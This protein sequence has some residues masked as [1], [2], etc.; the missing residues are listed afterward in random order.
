[1]QNKKTTD[2]KSY[3]QIVWEQF[4]SRK[5]A[6]FGLCFVITLF[7]IALYAPYLSFKKPFIW[8]A[9]SKIS[10][11]F[12]RDF[13]APSEATEIVLEK[14]FNYFSIFLPV[15]F[16]IYYIFKKFFKIKNKIILIAISILALTLLV[17]FLTVN[18]KLDTTPYRQLAEKREGWGFFPPLR[19]GPF[20]QGFGVRKA[21]DWVHTDSTR[22]KNK[23]SSNYHLMGTDRVGRDV[24]ARMIHGSRVSLAVGIVSVF[25]STVIGIII[26]S[27]AG[28]FGGWTDMIIS[29]IIEIVICFPTFFL[30]LTIIAILPERSILNIIL[31][32]GLLG[33]TGI[34]RLVRGEVLKQRS[35]DYVTAS[36]AL[37]ASSTRTIFRHILPN[38][39]APVLVSI[40]FG[41]AGSILTE[42][43]LSF[44]GV[45]VDIPTASW[46]E[47]L[48]QAREAPQIY[49]W[50]AIFPGLP[51]FLTV[52]V[53]NLV[54]E[55]LRDAMDP[56]S[57]R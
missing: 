5:G 14:S 43:S 17:P 34:A 13:F 40:S 32:L 2:T 56:R 15:A 38:S 25:I 4:S 18:S 7:A 37:G 12:W 19:Y 8:V 44:L 21:P 3:S 23:K 27:I 36:I 20:E 41:I 54:G 6:I 45:G 24:F 9:D 51:I 10:F 28:Y 49:W 48:N 50:L 57:G 46:G 16:G 29:R 1:M 35:L 31:I 22:Q 11:P 42:S 55:G 30:I 52:T 39:L 47:L 33:W 53:Y 26:G